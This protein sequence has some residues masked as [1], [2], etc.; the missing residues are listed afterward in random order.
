MGR[1]RKSKEKDKVSKRQIDAALDD[2]GLTEK[3]RA[4]VK[5]F[6]SGKFAGNAAKS[7]LAAGYVTRNAGPMACA[8]AKLPHIQ[9][10][11]DKALRAELAGDLTTHAIRVIRAILLDENAP[12]KLRGDMAAKVVEFSGI[13]E[14]V[15]IEK[16]KVTG[17]DGVAQAPKR[18]GEMSRQELESLVRN[19]AAI[20]QAAASLPPA[21]K[22]IEGTARPRAGEGIGEKEPAREP[23]KALEPA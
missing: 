23:D 5:E 9:A 7:I 18:L 14:R 3:Q 12:L 4:Y 2:D 20:L 15:R 8:I 6:T 16:A 10:A 17:L 11:I 22:T 1:R 19:G 13:V 21:D